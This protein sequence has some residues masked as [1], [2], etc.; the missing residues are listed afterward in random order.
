MKWSE[1]KAKAEKHGWKLLRHGGR[2]DI[3]VHPDKD[4]QIQ[5]E[6]HWSSEVKPGLF[7][8]LKKQIGF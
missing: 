8:K 2:H 6:R 1:M 7:Y 4:Y 3:Y 5:I